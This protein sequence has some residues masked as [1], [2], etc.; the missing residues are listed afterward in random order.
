MQALEVGHLGAVTSL[1]EH[2]KA[3]LDEGA[4]TTAKDGLLAEEVGFGFFL[5]G[6]LDDAAAGAADAVCPGESDLLGLL[7]GVL[8]D[9]DE[10]GD[11]L[12]FGVLAADDVAGA[13]RG[14]HDDVHVLR[15]DDGLV[16]NGEAVGEEEGFALGEVRGDVLLVH[17]A[18]LGVRHSDEDDVGRFDRIRGVHDLEAL[19]FSH[20]TA[21]GARVKAD[22]DFDAALLEVQG[23]GVALGAEADDSASL[24]FEG[25]EARV[26]FSVDF[27]G[28]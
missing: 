20:R 5:E 15:R 22:D 2:F 27:G 13:F 23:V 8:M 25:G 19:F 14:H 6:G 26:F 4:G 3:G 11:A 16:E 21:L 24:A 9:G 28:H 7:V 17:A 18:D 12:A 1:G 10:G